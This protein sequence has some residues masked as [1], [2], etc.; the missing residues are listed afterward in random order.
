MVRKA[1]RAELPP[2]H[3]LSIGLEPPTAETIAELK[4]MEHDAAWKVITNY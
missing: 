1:E 4:A 2:D 3:Y